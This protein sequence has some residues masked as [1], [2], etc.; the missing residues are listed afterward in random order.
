[1]RKLGKQNHANGRAIPGRCPSTLAMNSDG[2]RWCRL[3]PAT[4]CRRTS[5]QKRAFWGNYG[6]ARQSTFSA[7]A[8]GCPTRLV[9]TKNYYFWGPHISMREFA[10]NC[11]LTLAADLNL[12]PLLTGDCRLYTPSPARRVAM[13][14]FALALL[15]LV[16]TLLNAQSPNKNPNKSEPPILGPHRARGVPKPATTNSN[17][18]LYH[19]GPILPTASV[20][21]IFWGSSWGTSPGDKITGMNVFY[22]SEG[23]TPYAATANEYTD[24]TGHQASSS[25][26]Y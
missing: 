21:A 15:V 23:G 4:R 8:T 10:S 12:T 3:C 24:S 7:R 20:Q 22:E 1:M 18:L 5:G 16:S 6:E 17:D 14:R 26:T 13:N 25:L 9:R 11:S 19:G 2:K